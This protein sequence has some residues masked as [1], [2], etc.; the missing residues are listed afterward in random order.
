M[1]RV[2]S[3]INTKLNEEIFRTFRSTGSD[4]LLTSLLLS[5]VII[6]GGLGCAE[7]GTVLVLFVAALSSGR[8]H[9]FLQILNVVHHGFVLY[10]LH[11]LPLIY[12]CSYWVFF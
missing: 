2:F 8:W 11:W 12:E 4:C 10:S 9:F 1:V 3:Y 7:G 6:S 5:S